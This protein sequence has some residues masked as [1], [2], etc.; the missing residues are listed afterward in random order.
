MQKVLHKS[1]ISFGITFEIGNKIHSVLQ[2]VVYS[3]KIK[4]GQFFQ[5]IHRTI[6]AYYSHYTKIGPH[7]KVGNILKRKGFAGRVRMYGAN[8]VLWRIG[9]RNMADF[10]FP[11]V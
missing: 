11:G 7:C 4:I 9:E 3:G 10:P 1:Y 5:N 6:V 2:N 8:R